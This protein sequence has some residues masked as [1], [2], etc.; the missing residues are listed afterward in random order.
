VVTN[1]EAE[2]STHSSDEE[3]MQDYNRVTFDNRRGANDYAV[4]IESK[5]F[6]GRIHAFCRH[7]T[8]S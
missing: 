5:V 1:S 8:F 6:S 4:A 2:Y 7:G 3:N